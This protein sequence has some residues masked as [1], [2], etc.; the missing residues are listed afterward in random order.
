MWDQIEKLLLVDKS[1][2]VVFHEIIR[3]GGLASDFN[4]VG[5]PELL[6]TGCWY[7]WWQRRRVVHGEEIQIAPR[8]AMSIAAITTN[9]YLAPKASTYNKLLFS[10]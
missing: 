10:S 7:I 8:A 3:Q 4:D 5:L 1:G 2:S 6:I 9:Y